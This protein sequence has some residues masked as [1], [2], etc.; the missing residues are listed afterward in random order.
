MSDV[1]DIGVYNSYGYATHTTT[2]IIMQ[3]VSQLSLVKTRFIQKIYRT[4]ITKVYAMTSKI[5]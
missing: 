5:N 3:V 4:Y 1:L 2:I